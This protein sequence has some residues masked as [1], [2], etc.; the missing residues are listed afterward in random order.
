[1]KKNCI[2]EHGITFNASVVRDT[3]R[4]FLLK[5]YYKDHTVY[6][7]SELTDEQRDINNDNVTNVN[8]NFNSTAFLKHAKNTKW[9][10]NEIYVDYMRMPHNYIVSRFGSQFFNQL[11]ELVKNKIL[12]PLGEIGGKIYLPF[13]P[14]FFIYLNS[15]TSIKKLFD[16][17]YL[18]SE[19]LSE[20]NHKLAFVTNSIK[21][22]NKW[23][24]MKIS[25]QENHITHTTKSL[26]NYKPGELL[27]KEQIQ[28]IIA[29]IGDVS[30][31]RFIVLT[32]SPNSYDIN[33]NILKTCYNYN[34]AFNSSTFNQCCAPVVNDYNYTLK[35]KLVKLPTDH[36]L[37]KLGEIVVWRL[38]SSGCDTPDG[39]TILAD[40]PLGNKLMLNVRRPAVLRQYYGSDVERNG[41]K[42]R[43][44]LGFY[45]GSQSEG[46]D[47]LKYPVKP[48]SRE[49]EKMAS[50]LKV[51]LNQNSVL[52]GLEEVD[53]IHDFNSCAVLLYHSLED[54]K[55]GSS[56]GWHYDTKYKPDGT[57]SKGNAIMYN[58]P[59]IIVIIGE[60][61]TLSWRKRV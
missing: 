31:I 15:D 33:N 2:D 28:E 53:L 27:T 26:M 29:T 30:Q 11:V 19:Q 60:K 23:L 5:R 47:R 42:V 4:S 37:K 35:S 32:T 39:V 6:T 7:I 57:Y 13:N 50:Y 55:T 34:D 21:N 51:L 10:F 61:R 41:N 17:S 8:C 22:E 36:P 3:W 1:M 9:H 48:F 14:H 46:S 44:T 25:D 45:K 18:T 24:G 40:Q 56:I 12:Q 58:T 54:I 49:L 52:Y 38:I 16:I 20:Q 43:A 59:I